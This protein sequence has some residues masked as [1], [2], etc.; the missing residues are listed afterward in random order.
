M[1]HSVTVMS[2]VFPCNLNGFDNGVAIHGLG[3]AFSIMANLTS[4]VTTGVPVVFPE[5]VVVSCE[6]GISWVPFLMNRLDKEYIERRREVPFLTERP[7]EYLKRWYY[8]TQPIEEPRDMAAGDDDRPLRRRRNTVF[9]SDWPHH[10]FDHPRKVAQ[11]PV[12]NETR[13]AIMGEYALRLF[14]IDRNARRNPR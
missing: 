6:A 2:P 5:L 10:D 3:H 7:S 11:I 4:M 9:A 13:R 1:L 12:D 14:G 8:S